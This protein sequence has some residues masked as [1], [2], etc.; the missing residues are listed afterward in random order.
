MAAALQ[1]T[2]T[3][4]TRPWERRSKRRGGQLSTRAAG[5]RISTTVTSRSSH[6]RRSSN[7]VAMDGGIGTTSAAQREVSCRLSTIGAITAWRYNL[8]LDLGVKI[9]IQIKTDAS[10]AKGIASRR[11]VGKIRHIEVSQLWV[12]DKV[13]K[14]EVIMRKVSTEENLAD[15]LTKHVNQDEIN[16]HIQH[17]NQLVSEG[18]HEL[19]PEIGS[20]EKQTIVRCTDINNFPLQPRPLICDRMHKISITHT[21]GQSVRGGVQNY[22]SMLADTLTSGAFD[23]VISSSCQD[24]MMH[25]RHLGGSSARGP[26]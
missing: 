18:R 15:A 7:M 13:R 26:N 22:S 5:P 2:T 25:Y 8:L 11:G 24:V 12:Q 10:A 4:A 3:R 16:Y 1:A 23:T 14:G 17:T 6:S 19:A 9:K 20:I 21:S